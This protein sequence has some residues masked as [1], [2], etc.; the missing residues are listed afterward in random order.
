M[1]ETKICHK[2]GIEKPLTDFY[3]RNKKL[4]IY[5]PECIECRKKYLEDNKEKISEQRKQGRI[6]NAEKIK[7]QKK[8]E[9]ERHKEKY[10]ERGKR[11]YKENA[12]EIKSKQKEY[13]HKNKDYI[14]KRQ[15]EYYEN[16]KEER[17]NKQHEYYKEHKEERAEYNKK[18]RTDNIEKLNEYQKEYYENNK[19]RLNAIS[20]EY[21]HT[22]KMRVWRREHKK[23]RKANDP[24]YKLSEQTRTLINNCFRKKGYRKNSKSEKILGC[25]FKTFYNYL[26]ETYK[27][28]YGYE[29]DKKE[30]VHIDHI[31]PISE[32]KTEKEIFELCKYTNLQLLKAEDNLKKSNKINYQI[33]KG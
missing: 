13:N 19:E 30:E 26:L 33:K 2:C 4:G 5:R 15:K 24:L 7:I 25:D 12:E 3:F 18:Y 14:L 1:V 8:E 27:N 6:R 17:I 22:D 32:A 23:E 9:Y 11:R 31:Y 16:N 28:N 20:K 29:L 10:S 21:S